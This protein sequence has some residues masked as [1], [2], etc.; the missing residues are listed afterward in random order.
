MTIKTWLQTAETVL[1]TVGIG[2]A[3]LDAL[4]LLEDVLAIDR[5]L[6]LA[7][8]DK[9]ITRSI[10]AKLEK[11]LKLRAEHVPLAYVRG[12]TEFYGRQFIVSPAV[13]E[14]RPETETMI[15]LLIKLVE[16]QKN[17]LPRTKDLHIADIGTGC[18]AI[19]ITAAL[20]LPGSQ[21]DL[22]EID[23]EARK[24]AQ[25]NVDKLTPAIPVIESN[26]M[27][28]APHEYQILLCNLPYVPDDYHIN[29]A[30]SHEPKLAI[31]GGQDGLDVYRQLF[32]QIDKRVIKP[33]Y[34]LTEALPPQHTVL[35][36][37]AADT[38]YSLVQSQDF[39]QVYTY[40]NN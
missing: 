3:R 11:L 14:P 40:L 18:G 28:S 13:L 25:M 37:I 39:I 7:E 23:A 17:G 22:L 36:N 34:V 19:G 21:V 5:A 16:S 31:F 8:P 29:R 9:I 4:V 35:E 12:R 2:T 24:I 38:G 6:L 27:A 32:L 33:L 20:E 10:I 26:L 30:A 15:D 1:S